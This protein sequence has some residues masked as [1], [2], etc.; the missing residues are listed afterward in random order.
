VLTLL[1]DWE[2]PRLGDLNHLCGLVAGALGHVLDLVDDFVAFKNLA[3][4]DVA[5]IEP[6]GD[7]G[8]NEEL[9]AVG[10]LARVRLKMLSVKCSI[11]MITMH[12]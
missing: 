8:G 3:E 12:H 10:V 6:A 7:D 5:S 1:S 2:L 4:N 9:G 11:V